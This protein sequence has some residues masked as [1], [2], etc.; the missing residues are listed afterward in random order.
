MKFEDYFTVL[1]NAAQHV[2]Y[3]NRLNKQPIKCIVN[4][5]D[6]SQEEYNE[7]SSP[8]SLA[9][10]SV[11]KV[12]TKV[13][14]CPIDPQNLNTLS[15]PDELFTK[16]PPCVKMLIHEAQKAELDYEPHKVN[17]HGVEDVTTD[18]LAL[19]IDNLE[20]SDYQ[21]EAVTDGN[22]ANLGDD[23]DQQILAHLTWCKVLPPSDIWQV[24]A[25]QQSQKAER[26]W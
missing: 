4:Y 2:D 23:N 18:S 13:P 8:P 7:Q 16:L 11:S 21:A 19:D 5:L 26:Q 14:K 15:V 1:Q 24:L 25:A 6:L 12:Q 3:E 20:I 17:F 22:A 9:E 10:L